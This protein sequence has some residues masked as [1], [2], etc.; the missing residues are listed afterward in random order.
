[1]ESARVQAQSGAAPA[2]SERTP[3]RLVLG[4]APGAPEDAP[5]AQLRALI[6]AAHAAG[7][8]VRDVLAAWIAQEALGARSA[9]DVLAA[10]AMPPS[11]LRTAQRV[12]AAYRRALAHGA[13]EPPAT[14]PTPVSRLSPLSRGKGGP[15]PS[16]SLV[17]VH[18]EHSEVAEARSAR[19]AD[20]EGP[21]GVDPLL[22]ATAR[23]AAHQLRQTLHLT[24]ADVRE[25]LAWLRT[26]WPVCRTKRDPQTYGI[27]VA[28]KRARELGLRPPSGREALAEL[29]T[30]QTCPRCAQLLLARYGYACKCSVSGR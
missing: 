14:P 1:M 6:D 28:L 22:E 19:G 25:C 11:A 5:T 18:S 30:A 17:S 27:A 21:S 12:L 20:R 4:A 10:L 15:M 8:D 7:E 2:E 9:P 24:E 23:A 3:L 13:I 29:N 26:Q 16:E